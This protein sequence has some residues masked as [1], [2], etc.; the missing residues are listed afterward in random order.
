MYFCHNKNSQ[1]KTKDLA[2]ICEGE[3][4]SPG[5]ELLL[6]P[7]QTASLRPL[8]PLVIFIMCFKSD[9]DEDRGSVIMMKTEEQLYYSYF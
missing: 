2:F 6:I 8:R 5:G 7:K 3:L 9:N 4:Q 1:S